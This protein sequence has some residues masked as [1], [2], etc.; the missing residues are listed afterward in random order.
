MNIKSRGVYKV[1]TISVR[2]MPL[3]VIQIISA[4]LVSMNELFFTSRPLRWTKRW[5]YESLMLIPGI[6]HEHS[7]NKDKLFIGAK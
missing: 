6:K 4:Y 3:S 7:G 5:T 2:W 1:T